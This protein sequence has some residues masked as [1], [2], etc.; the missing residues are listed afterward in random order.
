MNDLTFSDLETQLYQLYQEGEYARALDLATRE[1]SRF[2][3][4]AWLVYYRPAQGSNQPP[5]G[6]ASHRLPAPLAA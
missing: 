2:P 4:E 5:C 6:H 1:A 3:T